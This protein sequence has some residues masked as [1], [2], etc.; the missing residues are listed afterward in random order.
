MNP[1]S[2]PGA[3]AGAGSTPGALPPLDPFLRRLDGVE[4]VR[5]RDAVNRA[6]LIVVGR[7]VTIGTDSG[8]LRTGHCTELMN[9]RVEGSGSL[10]VGETVSITYPRGSQFFGLRAA[11]AS[12]TRDGEAEVVRV[13]APREAYIFPGRQHVRLEGTLGAKVVLKV[14]DLEI[15]ARGIDVSTGGLGV[16]VGGIGVLIPAADGFVIGHSFDV[17]LDFG[18]EVISLEA[19]VRTAVVEGDSVRLGMEFVSRSEA[20]EARILSAVS[21]KFETPVP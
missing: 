10:E 18:D 9:F 14:E 4:T 17:R 6:A 16:S 13:F 19:K 20:L 11:V 2:N 5:H 1:T 8:D 15:E 3:V 12:S 21:A 7:A